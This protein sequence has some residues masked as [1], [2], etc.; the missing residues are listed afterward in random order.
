V[1]KELYKKSSD[2]PELATISSHSYERIFNVY[3]D[4]DFYAYNINKTIH[5]PDDLDPS[6][7]D[8]IRISGKLA[9]SHISFKVYGTIKLWWL[10]CLV[11]KI[12]NPVIL[13]RPGMIIKIIKPA[14]VKHVI[15]QID[16]QI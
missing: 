5:F 15:G 2:I 8:H 4:D 7:I 16:E 1:K 12:L 10:L 6:F 13:P 14:A 11:N 3:T 9:W